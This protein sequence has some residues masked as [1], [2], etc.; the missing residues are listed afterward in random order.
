M[1][2]FENPKFPNIAMRPGDVLELPPGQE[3]AH[4]MHACGQNAFYI[5]SAVSGCDNDAI[6]LEE[7]PSE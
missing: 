4:K 5:E 7:V 1:V 3:Y 6:R 2:S